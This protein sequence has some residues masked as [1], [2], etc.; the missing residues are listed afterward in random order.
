MTTLQT[1][2]LMSGTS[3]DGVD[4][5]HVT[6]QL[7]ENKDWNFKLHHAALLHFPSSLYQQLKE[8]P[9]LSA[10]HLCKLSADL[11]R[12]YGQC[13]NDFLQQ[14]QIDASSIDFISSHGQ[15]VF[16]QPQQGF[17]LQIGNGPELS[18]ST[19]LPSIVDFRSKDVALGG[20]GAPLI[21]VADFLLFRQ[22]AS[23][24]LNLGGFSNLSF[25][26]NKSILSYDVCPVNIIIN[27]LMETINKPFDKD[28]NLG[29]T[30]KINKPLL[31]QLNQLSFYHT[32]GPKSLGWEWVEEKILPLIAVSIPLEDK[33][34]TLYE[35]IGIQLGNTFQKINGNTI[36]ITGG[37]AKNR[38]LIE[39]IEHYANK[40]I[41]LPSTAIIDYKE[42]I[43]FAFLGLLRW[44]NETNIWSSVTGAQK[45]SCSGNIIFP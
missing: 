44:R 38:F 35:H 1:I 19:Q 31:K 15:T 32:E 45:D 42:A 8:A 12:F 37:G 34:R 2:G 10:P 24:F 11:G 7:E 27:Y 23:I 39:R 28:G 29:R 41:N 9:T 5:V 40:E 30:G 6:F 21:P 17:T 20:T 4:V 25:Q 33:I 3:L 43:G 13:V 26:E 36:L 22:Y 16:H 14:Y 18:T